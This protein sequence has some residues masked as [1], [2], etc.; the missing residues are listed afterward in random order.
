MTVTTST[1][2]GWV[3]R[4]VDER[5]GDSAPDLPLLSVSEYRGVV[6]RRDDGE[7][8]AASEDLSHYKVCRPEDIVLNRLWAFRGGLGRSPVKGLVSPDYAVLRPEPGTNP[9]FLNYLFRS[10]TFVAEMAARSRGIGGIDAS[11]GRSPRINMIDF[12]AIEIDLPSLEV[13]RRVADF[14]DD[15][16][17]R[18]HTLI[19]KNK[20]V[21][22]LLDERARAIVS[23]RLPL[24]APRV[25]IWLLADIN[26]EA[27]SDETGPDTTINYIDIGAVTTGR[28]ASPPEPMEFGDAPSR[29]RRVLKPGDILVSTVRTYL[30]AIVNIAEGAP[31]NLIGSTGF[32]VLRPRPV[33]TTRYM[34]YA[35]LNDGFISEVEARS[36]GVS[37]PAISATA[38]G[39]VRIPVP[40][41]LAQEEIV[42]ELEAATEKVNA[43]TRRVQDQIDLLAERKQ[44]LITAAVTGQL[45]I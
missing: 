42:C 11:N 25:P 5:A 28:M 16:T 17:A 14:L 12:N 44:A 7:G 23:E 27:L 2:A 1:R 26:P 9:R 33:I 32:A 39:E 24:D 15:Q 21:M 8:Q 22:A 30:R 3:V 37:Y 43:L 6:P 29:A 10:P 38:V 40:D 18:I 19:V 13:Q 36:D 4:E 31:A 34:M 41:A 20:R 45:D 35:C